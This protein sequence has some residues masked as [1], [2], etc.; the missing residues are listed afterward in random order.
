MEQQLS[1]GNTFQSLLKKNLPHAVFVHCHCHLLQLVCV[2]EANNING[3]KLVY[4]TLPSLWK[5]FPYSP[6]GAECLKE[7]QQVLHLPELKTIKLSDTRWLAHKRCVKAVKGS[8]SAIVNALSNIYER[9]H[10]PEAMEISKFFVNP[11]QYLSS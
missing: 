4:I 6:K 8:Y 1:L 3:I 10:E 2:N 5:F 7:V 11:Q 9:T